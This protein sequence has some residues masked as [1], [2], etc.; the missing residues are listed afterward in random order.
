MLVSCSRILYMIIG[1][2]YRPVEHPIKY[3][4]I[5]T[6]ISV[7]LIVY[8]HAPVLASNKGEILT[9]LNLADSLRKADH[10]DS[11]LI[12]TESALK[13]AE[14]VFGERDR[15]VAYVYHITG[16]CYFDIKKFSQSEQLFTKSVTLRKELLGSDHLE[17]A[18]SLI[19]LG[20]TYM[21]L[22]KY[23]DAENALRQAQDIKQGKLGT[24]H[25]D[26]AECQSKLAVI[27][28]IRGKYTDAVNLERR[29]L[30]IFEES[31][32]PEH[33]KVGVSLFN[34]G[35]TYRYLSRYSEA[36]SLYLRAF[37]IRERALGSD[38]PEVGVILNYLAQLYNGLDRHAEAERY[39][40]RALKIAE[41]HY[42]SNHTTVAIC[43]NILGDI[44]CDLRKYYQA[45]QLQKKALEINEKA[46]GLENIQVAP[47][48]NDLANIY[49]RTGSYS[50]AEPLYKRALAIREKALGSDHPRTANRYNSLAKLYACM[51]KSAE[52]H[53]YFKRLHQS[54][55]NFIEYAFSY[56]SE[57][58]KIRF[59]SKHSP[60]IDTYIFWALLNDSKDAREF[61]LDML[62]RGK[63]VVLDAVSA[64]H[65]IAYC[66]DDDEI[67]LMAK[68]HADI[69]GEIAAL[70]LTGPGSL[71]SEMYQNRLRILNEAKDSLEA[72]LSKN[73]SEYRNE[74]NRNRFSLHDIAKALP[75]G[76]ILWEFVKYN[77]YDF[78]KLGSDEERT[79]APRYLA[80]TY[81]HEQEIT[82]YDLGD[83][84]KIDEIILST[85][86]MLYN[87][88]REIYK[89]GDKKAEQMLNKLTHRLYN[90]IFKPLIASDSNISRIFISPDAQLNLLPFEILPDRDGCYA[91]ERY[92]ISYLSSGRDLLKYRGGPEYENWALVMANPDFA[93]SPQNTG[94]R[95]GLTAPITPY[96]NNRLESYRGGVGC[97]SPD[98]F[99]SLP[100]TKAE[101][102]A[103]T[104][105]LRLRT[106]LDVQAYY[107]ADALEEVLKGMTSCPRVL[108]LAT[109]GFFCEDTDLKREGL[110]ENPLLRSGI[111]LAGAN[112]FSSEKEIGDEIRI[113]DGIATA[114]EISGLNLNGTELVVLSACET[115][116]GEA[117]NGE[118]IYG[119]RRAFQHAGARSIIMSLWD[120]PDRETREIMVRFYDYWLD[121]RSK[122]Q[123]LRLSILDAIGRLRDSYGAAHPYLWGALFLLGD[124]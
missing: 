2:N 38:H 83:A 82:M 64:E 39:A 91:I 84:G 60:I 1:N 7:L 99:P 59:A 52:A 116:V 122:Q 107:G 11:A 61:A 101:A 76:S 41:D 48:L 55:L 36:E 68:H 18:E 13:E 118:G 111:V 25:P 117:K 69:C 33:D 5:L 26:V 4:V 77:T 23:A 75:E 6:L 124:S 12:Y 66:S 103:V 45:E 31:L 74:F 88:H 43:M 19:H 97:L 51:G 70:T 47:I 112:R 81:N 78:R 50:E 44:Y 102:V 90:I 62:L 56:A 110:S 15:M 10:P 115:G 104:K 123:A 27:Y 8:L 9:A 120:V 20:L 113:E 80:I 17:T 3:T 35:T 16:R 86:A 46:L 34:L 87:A 100:H 73:C 53:S 121:G 92:K 67:E 29:I 32:G 65:E 108:H 85:R 54:R 71:N 109:H 22:G 89:Y 106:D 63:A 57:E 24:N 40:K 95:E 37:A 21:N 14:S 105:L 119:L 114:F 72:E 93:H 94:I 98:L 49:Y 96:S 58:Q 79:G 28:R 30:R 42:G